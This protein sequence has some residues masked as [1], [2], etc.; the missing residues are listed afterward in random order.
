MAKRVSGVIS[1]PY[2]RKSNE[3]YF[4]TLQHAVA[5]AALARRRLAAGRIYLALK[6]TST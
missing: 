6:L 1:K 4:D 3:I 2:L 5:I